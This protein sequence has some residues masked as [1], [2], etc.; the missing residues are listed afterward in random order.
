MVTMT[1]AMAGGGGLTY[2][3]VKIIFTAGIS[4]SSRKRGRKSRESRRI[5]I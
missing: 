1:V 4:W 5:V 2:I 3:S